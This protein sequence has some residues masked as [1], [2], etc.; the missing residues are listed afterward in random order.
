MVNE[1]RYYDGVN[2]ARR[3]TVPGYFSF[4]YNDNVVPPTT[5]YGTYNVAGGDKT[6]SPYQQTA[7]FWYQEQWDEWQAYLL[8]HLGVS[9]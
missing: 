6:F 8:K 2:F 5:A 3:I 9:K 7:H 1:A 4:G